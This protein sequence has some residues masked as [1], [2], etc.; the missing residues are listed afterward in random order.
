MS[1]HGINQLAGGDLRYT[2]NAVAVGIFQSCSLRGATPLLDVPERVPMM[3]RDQNAPEMST[4]LEDAT[5]PP[6]ELR[7]RF[8]NFVITKSQS[9]QCSAEV[10]LELDGSRHLGKSTGTS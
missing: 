9:G 1:I 6:R 2:R 4:Q 8:A 7:V 5:S 10:T 3:P